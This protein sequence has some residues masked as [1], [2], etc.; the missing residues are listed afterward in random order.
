[1]MGA[2]RPAVKMPVR[3]RPGWPWCRRPSGWAC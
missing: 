3:P 1:M 2:S